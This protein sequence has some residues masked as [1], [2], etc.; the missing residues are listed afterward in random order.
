MA[1]AA[2]FRRQADICLRLSLIATDPELATRLLAMAED[3]KAKA[4]AADEESESEPMPPEVMGQQ[5]LPDGEG[6]RS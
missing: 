6:D 1:S 2:Y 3:Y 4:G 5:A